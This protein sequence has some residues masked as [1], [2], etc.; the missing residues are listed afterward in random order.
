MIAAPTRWN[1]LTHERLFHLQA[2]EKSGLFQT[3]CDPDKRFSYKGCRKFQRGT[4]VRR[5]FISGCCH[6]FV[7]KVH[8]V[9]LLLQDVRGLPCARLRDTDSMERSRTEIASVGGASF[10]H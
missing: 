3:F 5:N 4:Q 6:F 7:H 8:K 2:D 9:F 10:D 1:T